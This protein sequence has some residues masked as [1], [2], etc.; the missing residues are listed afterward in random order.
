[1]AL[2]WLC[3]R[4]PWW[5]N[6]LPA[7]AG[8]PG[9]SPGSGRSPGGGHGI[10]LQDSCLENPMH[11]GARRAAVPGSQASDTAQ[12]HPWLRRLPGERLCESC[13]ASRGNKL[14]CSSATSC[15]FNSGFASP[16]VG[17]QRRQRGQQDNWSLQQDP[18]YR[19]EK[20][21]QWE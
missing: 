10:P 20:V 6:T 2:L 1:M 15:L 4:L 8:D 13:R 18:R 9:S 21:K 19:V 12:R 11:R 14:V 5:A 17:K 7:N 3:W 16:G